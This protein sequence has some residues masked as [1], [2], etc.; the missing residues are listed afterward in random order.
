MNRIPKA[1]YTK[2]FL[3]EGQQRSR[4][5][6]IAQAQAHAVQCG[7]DSSCNS[8]PTRRSTLCQKSLFTQ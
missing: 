6:S 7:Y 2:E 4:Y 8:L 5:A 1:T 3:E